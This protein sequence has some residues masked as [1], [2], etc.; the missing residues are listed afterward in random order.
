VRRAVIHVK[1][2]SYALH[3]KIHLCVNY[4]FFLEILEKNQTSE[5]LHMDGMGL[6]EKG[7]FF[8]EQ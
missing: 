3:N 1:Q 5:N 4:R 8:Q 7:L 2:V 6:G